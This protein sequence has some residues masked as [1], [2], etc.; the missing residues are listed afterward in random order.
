MKKQTNQTTLGRRA[1][2]ILIAAV[3]ILSLVPAFTLTASAATY[4]GKA[5]ANITWSLDTDIGVLNITSTGVMDNW[6]WY[7]L[8]PWADHIESI[9]SVVISDGI[10]NIGNYAFYNCTLLES[11]TI[12]DSVTIIGKNAF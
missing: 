12:P 6:A 2:S 10:T 11:V 9:K 5:G 3:M 7:D 1:L 8:A 4:D